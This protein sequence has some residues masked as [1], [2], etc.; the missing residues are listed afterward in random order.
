M[1]DTID[2]SVYEFV[3][4]IEEKLEVKA[5]TTMI[6][7]FYSEEIEKYD[8]MVGSLYERGS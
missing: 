7:D 3:V 4:P 2:D 8:E 1:I 6:M 5:L